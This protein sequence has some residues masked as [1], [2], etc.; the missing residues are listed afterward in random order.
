MKYFKKGDL[1]TTSVDYI[2]CFKNGHLYFGNKILIF[3][4]YEEEENYLYFF[5]KNQYY[6]ARGILYLKS[7]KKLK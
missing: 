4:K 5:Y 6:E 2:A 7:F 3:I 1:I